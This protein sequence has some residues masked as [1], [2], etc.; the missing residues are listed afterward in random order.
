MQVEV[1]AGVHPQAPPVH[2]RRTEAVGE[3]RPHVLD[4]V[5][6]SDVPADDAV[7]HDAGAVTKAGQGGHRHRRQRFRLALVEG[8]DGDEGAED[9]VASTVGVRRVPAGVSGLGRP[10]EARQ[11]GG[12]GHVELG[13]TDAEVGLGRRLDPVGTATEVDGVQVALED[14][15]LVVATLELDGERRL[16]QLAGEGAVVADEDVLHVLLGDGRSPLERTSPEVSE[17][18]S[19]DGGDID[20]RMGEEVTVLDGEDSFDEGGRH[21]FERHR[22]AVLAARQLGQPVPVGVVDERRLHRDRLRGEGDVG[23]QVGDPGHARHDHQPEGDQQGS[24]S[25]QQAAVGAR[26]RRGRWGGVVHRVGV[27]RRRRRRVTLPTT[28]AATEAA[29]S[30]GRHVAAGADRGRRGRMGWRRNVRAR[31]FQEQRG[32]TSTT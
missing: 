5:L 19:G 2:P 22:D 10:D 13:G 12:S 27:G 6:G 23:E 7:L 21:L 24:G 20:A 25:S 28:P 11:V 16:P 9:D 8:A 29:P 17:G 30:A 15:V 31:W 4:E 1:Q 14:V 3:L 32:H 26:R 18:G